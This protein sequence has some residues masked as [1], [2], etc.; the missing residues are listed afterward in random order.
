LIVIH[1]LTLLLIVGAYVFIEFRG[2]FPRGSVERELMKSLHYW[3]GLSVLAL[4]LIRIALRILTPTPQ[5]NPPVPLYLHIAAWGAHLAL[6]AFMIVVPILGWMILSAEGDPTS[7]F[8][9]PLFPIVAPDKD[10]AGFA[11]ELHETIGD[12]GYYL[13]A[14]HAA[15]ALYHHYWR[16]DDTLA[17]MAPFLR[18]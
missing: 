4:V 18:K 9:I 16:R 5:I 17:H 7:F 10:F 1:W 6:Y 14:L 3:F 13:I 2:N 12:I 15:A 11:E 8:G